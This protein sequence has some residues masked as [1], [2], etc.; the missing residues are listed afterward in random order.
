MTLQDIKDTVDDHAHAAKGAIEAGFDCVEIVGN[1]LLFE[2]R[3]GS[4][5]TKASGNGYLLDQFLNTNTN[6]RADDHGGNKENGPERSLWLNGAIKQTLVASPSVISISSS[7][8]TLRFPR[9]LSNQNQ[10]ILLA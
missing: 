10:N 2:N 1:D 7:H 3:I 4:C 9:L 5:R 6:L 8:I